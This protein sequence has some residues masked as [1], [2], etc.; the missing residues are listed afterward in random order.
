MRVRRTLAWHLFT[1]SQRLLA[2][3]GRIAGYECPLGHLAARTSRALDQV[4]RA[5]ATAS[6][7][8][9]PAIGR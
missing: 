7:R 6:R 9:G 1:T 5:E 4:E 2:V 3:A 8:S